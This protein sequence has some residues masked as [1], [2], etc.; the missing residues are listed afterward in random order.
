MF[1]SQA[2]S[3]AQ[4]A[5]LAVTLAW[6]AGF[7][8]IITLLECGV[9]TSHVTGTAA[10]LGQDVAEGLWTPGGFAMYLLTAFVVG[11]AL[12]GLMT[13]LGRRRGWESLY[14]LP[15]LAQAVL[16]G[17]VAVILELREGPVGGAGGGTIDH[18][19]LD[20]ATLAIVGLAAMAMGLQNATITRISSGVVRTT[21]VTGV[22][23]DLGT[24]AV[25]LA[26][27]VRDRRLGR[28]SDTPASSRRVALLA[29]ILGSFALGAGLGA[30][31][32]EHAAR[33]AMFPPVA[34]LLWMIFQDVRQPIAEIEP[35][36]LVSEAGLRLPAEIAV[37]RV[38][39]D[40]A[41]AGQVH[42]MPDLV[43]WLEG[44]PEVVRVLVLDLTD[45]R[46]LDA[47][48]AS[49]LRA[50]VRRLRGQGRSLVL[51]GLTPEQ[52]RQVRDASGG[53]ALNAGRAD[54][55]DALDPMDVCPDLE[56]AVA[57]ALAVVG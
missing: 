8:N 54:A 29:S 3:F 22:L 33:W 50:A 15:M 28:G 32:H 49:E 36:T 9:A 10:K 51:A 14:V 12:S 27:A 44:L 1:I 39:K 42:R 38:R 18:P 25:H 4:Q 2:H 57:R 52:Y 34:F 43:G 46:Q 16:L 40:A 47:D 35:D 24:E 7:T 30:L 21:H 6:V 23:T 11:A 26:W 20:R 56:L 17:A 45:V 53:G 19:S 13:E 48:S 5:R 41:R 37:Y 55:R 31:M